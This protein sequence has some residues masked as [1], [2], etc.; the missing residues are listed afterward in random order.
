MEVK[1]DSVTTA[2]YT[3][4]DNGNRL[5]GP[6][7]LVPATYDDQDRL[8]QYGGAAYTY[9]ANGELETKTVGTAVTQY[10]YDPLGNLRTVTLP[11]GTAIEYLVDGQSR[12]I[13]KKVNG[14]LVQGFLYQDGLKPIAELDGSG[15]VVSR[16]VYATHAN[17]PDYMIRGGITYRI[18]TDHLGSPRLVL[19]TA[20]GSVVQRLDY[21]EFGRLLSGS[22]TA[23]GFQ[24]PFGFAG[25][26]Y[27]ADTGLVR[28]G[29]RDYDAETGR[30]TVK[31]PIGLA[32]GVNVYKYADGNPVNYADY[33]GEGPWLVIVPL[34]GLGINSTLSIKPSIAI[35]PN[36]RGAEFNQ[37][38]DVYKQYTY[39]PTKNENAKVAASCNVAARDVAGKLK[40]LRLRNFKIQVMTQASAHDWILISSQKG[41]PLYV[42]DP[43]RITNG[44]FGYGA[45]QHNLT[46]GY[47][48]VWNYE[49]HKQ[50]IQSRFPVATPD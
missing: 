29:A 35:D 27:D 48:P 44:F 39:D 4:D 2:S 49:D 31:D 22:F 41:T 37:I 16:F 33:N 42:L 30:W 46:S 9:T 34:V 47:A 12:R 23:P 43:I 21:D 25:G 45:G 28:F 13:G 14:T 50:R 26:L 1:K 3:Y 20:D 10:H 32:G 11:G 40:K 5:T 24:Q 17:V 18:I 19:D 7:L 6:G 8:T 36:T 38:Y 15:N